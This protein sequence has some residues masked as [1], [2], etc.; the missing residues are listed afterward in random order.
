MLD[1][2][3]K[4][5]E[6]IGMLVATITPIYFNPFIN[7][8][9]ET[10]K[11]M[12]FR[13]VVTCL[14]VVTGIL[15][16]NQLKRKSIVEFDIFCMTRQIANSNP[17]LTPTLA[18]AGVTLLSAILSI[19]RHA[20]FASMD[21]AHGTVTTLYAVVFCIILSFFLQCLNQVDHIITAIVIGSVPVSIYG[22]AQYVG[23]DTINWHT[24]SVSPVQSMLSRS[25]FLGGYL[26]MVMPFTVA[27][28]LSFRYLGD[29][30][31]ISYTIVGCLQLGCLFFTL[32]RGAWLGFLGG[33]IVF[34]WA[35]VHEKYKTRLYMLSG[36]ILLF[37]MLGFIFIYIYGDIIFRATPHVSSLSLGEIRDY[38][39]KARI[40]TWKN[41]IDLALNHLWF[42]YG[43][44]TF[45]VAYKLHFPNGLPGSAFFHM[46]DPHNLFLLELVST[47]LVGLS[48]LFW[49]LQRFYSLIYKNINRSSKYDSR[50]LL[51][52]L[53]G[54]MT[55]YLV[56]AQF[57]PDTIVYWV[58]FWLL[59]ASATVVDRM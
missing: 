7:I 39:N 26:A 15:F 14:V 58:I 17:L 36:L 44:G 5:V 12:F 8:S 19:D 33:M 38:S 43:P 18:F 22:W 59:V 20:S 6:G 46:D 40:V 4:Y 48:S 41:T 35:V 3:K 27:R 30:R 37:G 29:S 51:A 47:G 54:S 24:D 45:T 11:I 52:A 10:S 9:L 23:L 2:F 1:I 16:I 25:I 21:R 28:I 55:A 53:S 56:Q 42:G 49:L 34:V 13:W 31:W 50:V 57:N 32:A